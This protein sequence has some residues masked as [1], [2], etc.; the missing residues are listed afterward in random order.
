MGYEAGLRVIPGIVADADLSLLQYT[1]VLVNSDS[2]AIANTT[3]GLKCAGVLQDAPAVAGRSASI[4]YA[5]ITKIKL[6]ATV[7]AGVWVSSTTA[8]LATTA[9]TT[10]NA[11][12]LLITGGILNDIVTMLIQP[13]YVP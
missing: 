9:L 7:A 8:G 13:I 4:A 5:G 1:F 2:E 6:G 12:G 3:L 11:M 10:H